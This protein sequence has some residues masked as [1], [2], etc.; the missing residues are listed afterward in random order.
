MKTLLLLIV[1]PGFCLAAN[2][3]NMTSLS[4]SSYQMMH[5]KEVGH[6]YHIYIKTPEMTAENKSQKFPTIYL[7]DGGNTYPMFVPYAKYLSWTDNTPPVIMVGISYGTDDYKKGNK[8]ST[9]FTLPAVGRDHYG[10]AEK[11][12]QFL[13]NELFPMIEK[14]YPSDPNQRILFGHSLGGQFGLYSAMFQPQTFSGII[15]SNPAIHRNTDSFLID[16]EPSEHQ[17]KLFI[18]QADNDNEQY[19]APRKKW[20]D[21]WHNKPHHWQKQVM[22]AQGHN[23]MSSLPVAFRQGMLW[24]FPKPND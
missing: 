9:D 12:H 20:L 10:G 22:T 21:Y 18:M 1:L 23:H 4:G 7:L 19:K 14:E 15:A 5:S 3:D 6:D 24:L 13:I 8:R 17:P 16:I 11:F 2:T